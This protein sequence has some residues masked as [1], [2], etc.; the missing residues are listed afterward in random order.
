MHDDDDDDDDDDDST[1]CTHKFALES[2]YAT[3]CTQQFL[4]R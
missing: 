2:L 3:L 4:L 1:A